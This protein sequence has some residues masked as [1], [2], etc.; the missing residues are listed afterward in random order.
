MRTKRALSIAMLTAMLLQHEHAQATE[1][2]PNICVGNPCTITGQ[3]DLTEG[4]LLDFGAKDVTIAKGALLKE[5][6]GG[7]FTLIAHD[8]TLAGALQTMSPAAG[9]DAGS[10][11]LIVSGDFTTPKGVPGRMVSQGSGFGMSGLLSVTAGGDINLQGSSGFSTRPGGGIQLT[12]NSIVIAEKLSALAGNGGF[13][14][15]STNGPVV[16]KKPL[17]A[18]DLAATVGCGGLVNIEVNGGDLTVEGPITQT[19][20]CGAGTLTFSA[21]GDVVVKKKIVAS[22]TG[23]ANDSGDGGG[24]LTIRADGNIVIDAPITTNG[25]AALSSSPGGSVLLLAGGEVR[26]FGDISA[27]GLHPE[28]PAGCISIGVGSAGT[29]QVESTLAATSQGGFGIIRLGDVPADTGFCGETH[30]G[31]PLGADVVMLSGKLDTSHA[32]GETRI[33][34]RSAFDATNGQLV[35]NGGVNIIQCAC[36]DVAPADGVCDSAT[37]LNDPVG[38][39]PAS[40]TPPAQLIPTMLAP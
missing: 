3:H 10:I 23:G 18:D 38:L 7:G 21:T 27:K 6:Q 39:N 20:R 16:I 36:P 5:Q 29:I 31:P 8:L 12:G 11:H 37:C 25:S 1:C 24:A 14:I 9:E 13:D 34:Y 4:C 26:V 40:A 30:A 2:D 32:D 22:D 28:A 19:N 35:A 17:R 15:R 33:S